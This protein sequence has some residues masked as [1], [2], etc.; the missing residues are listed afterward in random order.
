MILKGQLQYYYHY[1]LHC[2]NRE[3]TGFILKK[4]TIIFQ[5]TDHTE[6]YFCKPDML[7]AEEELIIIEGR[8]VRRTEEDERDLAVNSRAFVTS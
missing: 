1:Y 4:S 8:C 2:V 6:G 3:I 7:I 5:E